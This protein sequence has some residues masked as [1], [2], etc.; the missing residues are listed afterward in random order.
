MKYFR[1]EQVFSWVYYKDLRL[2][3]KQLVHK[4]NTSLLFST[5]LRPNHLLSDNL[6]HVLWHLLFQL[7][8][9]VSVYHH[10]QRGGGMTCLEIKYIHV[11]MERM[12][13]TRTL[14]FLYIKQNRFQSNFP[15][16]PT[17]IVIIKS[18]NNCST[19]MF[20][21]FLFTEQW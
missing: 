9:G 15:I 8:V 7:S 14:N 10:G 18:Y 6:R 21:L 13:H 11:N 17:N 20:S 1:V 19:S 5:S 16:S 4:D 12:C 2:R 3:I